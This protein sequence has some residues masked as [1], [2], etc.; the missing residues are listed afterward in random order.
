MK[1]IIQ[2]AILIE[3]YMHIE[4]KKMIADKSPMPVDGNLKSCELSYVTFACYR[5]QIWKQTRNT[6][7]IISIS[8]RVHTFKPHIGM[9]I[10]WEKN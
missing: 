5:F 10:C 8:F 2:A 4:C 6:H 1:L 9:L 7:I 3:K